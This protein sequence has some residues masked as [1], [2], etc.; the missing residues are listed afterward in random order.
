MLLLSLSQLICH[1]SLVD[2][3]ILKANCRSTA[4]PENAS[5]SDFLNA[6]AFDAILII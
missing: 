2:F 4:F 5:R 3:V 6:E 1:Q